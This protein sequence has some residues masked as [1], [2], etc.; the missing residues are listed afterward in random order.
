MSIKIEKEIQS[1]LLKGQS[2]AEIA[3]QLLKRKTVRQ[4][5]DHFLYICHFMYLAGL[6]TMI[7]QIALQQLSKK[8]IVP[9]S[10][11]IDI[12]FS[13]QIDIPQQTRKFFLKGIKEQ[14]QIQ[15]MLTNRCWDEHHPELYHWK[16]KTIDRIHQKNNQDLIKLMEDL[17]FIQNQGVLNKEE[18][19]LEKLKKIDPKNPNIQG[20][21]DK[22]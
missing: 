19:I 6:Y 14:N 18:E 1:G 3:S 12:L 21:M 4:E 11:V 10:F 17:E 16:I 5:S 15:Q 2:S 20:A 7:L 8:Q 22:I 9:W 13:H